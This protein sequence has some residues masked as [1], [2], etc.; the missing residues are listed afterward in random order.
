MVTVWFFWV[1]K[2]LSNKKIILWDFIY[3]FCVYIY[4]LFVFWMWSLIKAYQQ[5]YS[6][7]NILSVVPQN[8]AG[9]WNRWDLQAR[10]LT[11]EK[12]LLG[13]KIPNVF[14]TCLYNTANW[15]TRKT[16]IAHEVGCTLWQRAQELET[17]FGPHASQTIFI[18]AG[19]VLESVFIH[20]CSRELA[21]DTDQ[22][23]F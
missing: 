20:G 15:W 7:R 11:L 19:I 22:T 8:R 12:S 6:I 9:C 16:V 14:L 13:W 17:F 3:S 21:A 2:I 23:I 1:K 10:V 4:L 5:G 18:W